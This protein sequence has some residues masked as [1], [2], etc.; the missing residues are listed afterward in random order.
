[1]SDEEILKE[2][3]DNFRRSRDAWSDAQDRRKEL[4]RFLGGNAWSEED[5]Q[6]RRD[7]KRPSLNHDELTQYVNAC[8]NATRMANRAIKV[9]PEGEGTDDRTAELMQDIVRTIEY[10]SRAHSCYMQAYADEVEGGYGFVRLTR[11]YVPGARNG[12]QEINI[13]SVQNPDTVLYD[14]DVREPD[15]SD[16]KFAFLL[17]AIPRKEFE[18]KYPGA[19]SKNFQRID[20]VDTEWGDEDNVLLAGYWRV[21]SEGDGPDVRKKV[22]QYVTNGVEILEENEEPGDEIPI[23][24]FIGKERF[25][26]VGGVT[27]RRLYALASLALSPQQSIA[28][29]V[30][31][32]AEEAALA[33][34][35]PFVGYAGQFETDREAWESAGKIPHPFLQ[36]DPVTDAT[37]ASVLPPPGRPQFVPNFAAYESAIEMARRAVQ[38]A[39][40]QNPL[41]TAAQRQNEKS[42][43]A[44][45]KIQQEQEIGSYHFA[46]GYNRALERLG[47]IL[48]AWIQKVY[49]TQRTLWVHK[50]DES[51][52]KIVLNTPQPYMNNDGEQEH[53]VIDPDAR[54]AVT[55]STGPSSQSTRDAAEDFLD[56][57]V[58]NL[59][60]LPLAPPQAQKLLAMAIQMRQL[61]PKGDQIAEIVSPTEG[62]AQIPP[63]A[64]QIVMQ[65]QQQ[66]QA[67][68]QQ[69][70]A[71]MAEIQ[72]LQFE[73]DARIVELQ[74]EFAIAKLKIEADLAK[75]EVSTK[76]Q[77]LMERE[78]IV[79]DVMSQLRDQAHEAG[80]AA[81]QQANMPPP[82]P[83]DQEGAQSAPPQGEQQPGQ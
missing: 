24:P 6:V 70:S 43:V 4:L 50:P 69:L 83:Q 62:Q 25:E 27:K 21:T 68:N 48:V 63:Q 57:L 53:H 74:G 34:K 13:K 36:V 61:G 52:K 22:T 64:Q 46:E 37:G 45:Q 39:M 80:M 19:Q 38:A 2:I 33:P 77:I 60:G 15:W 14:P 5:L 29:Y 18:K 73:K 11:S 40:A 8:I 56:T 76:A 67:M 10:R 1:M 32:M 41:P 79:A 42:G 78:G 28:Y 66:V 3:R 65:A 47:R 54:H 55:V 58:Q 12:E 44:L 16:A 71:A 81:Q 17:E 31:C 35:A 30:S 7:A 75:S 9:E 26:Q 59:K 82:Q 23:V 20:D 72:K 51:R 49:D